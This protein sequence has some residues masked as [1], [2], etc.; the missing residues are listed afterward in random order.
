MKVAAW[1]F[2]AEETRVSHSEILSIW[3]S[4]GNLMQKRLYLRGRKAVL[5]WL[6]YKVPI[7]LMR[8]RRA[9]LGRHRVIGD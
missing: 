4:P 5:S 7:N 8:R 3:K 2:D 6:H 1:R 9:A